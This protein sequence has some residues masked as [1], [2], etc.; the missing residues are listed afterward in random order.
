MTKKHDFVGAMTGVVERNK[1]IDGKK[2]IETDDVLIGL[3]SSGLH[4][5]G[6]S[7]IRSLMKKYPVL[8]VTLEVQKLSMLYKS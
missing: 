3:P 7:L 2:T 6:Y 4:T 5:N 8:A 1:I